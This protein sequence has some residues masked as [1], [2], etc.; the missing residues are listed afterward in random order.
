MIV[1]RRSNL[2]PHWATQIQYRQP[3]KGGISEGPN[4][5]WVDIQ[6]HP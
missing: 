6:F 5:W 4:W 3:I 2:T 1:N